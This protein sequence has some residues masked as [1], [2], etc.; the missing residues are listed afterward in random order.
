[1]K[2]Q[3]VRYAIGVGALVALG[4]GALIVEGPNSNTIAVAVAGGLGFLFGHHS[5][6]T[7]ETIQQVKA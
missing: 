1:M 5:A 4:T 3:T 7:T 2:D 6:E